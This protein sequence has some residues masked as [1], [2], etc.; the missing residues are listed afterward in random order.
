M[1]KSEFLLSELAKAIDAE[2]IGQDVAINA[3]STDTRTINDG[4]L[5]IAL[6]GERFDAHDFIDQAV[7]QGASAVVVDHPVECAIPQLVVNDTRIALGQ[8]SAY[9]RSLF[10]GTT[11]AITGSSGKTTVKEMLSVVMQGIDTTLATIGN[12]NNEIGVPLT[13]LRLAPE[14]RFAVIEMGASG[15]NEIAYSV[16]LTQPDIAMVNNAMA[17]HLEGFGSLEG[18]VQAKGEIYE[19][20]RDGG[21]AVVNLDDPASEAWLKR[22]PQSVKTLTY[23]VA[24][25]SA[26]ICVSHIERQKHGGHRFVIEA[27][28]QKVTAELS[29]LGRHNVANAAAVASMALAAGVSLEKVAEGIARFKAVKGRLCSLAGHSD[30]V[31]ID[32]TYNANKG[33]VMAAIDALT[34]LDGEATLVLGDLGELGGDAKAIHRELGKYA[35]SKGVQRLFAVGPLCREA[36]DG[37]QKAGGESAAHFN[38]KSSLVNAMLPLMTARTRI[39]VKGSRSSGMETVVDGLTG[40]EK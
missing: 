8:I 13:L 11:F 2:L 40:G 1:M 27:N 5:F 21:T 14:H 19:G 23:S 28:G 25:K 24:G 7:S 30:S 22:I 29:V 9:N 39:V 34:D 35:A 26:D 15:P 4:S 12:L 37:F 3:V 31:V 38:D 16:G 32:D 10:S 6:K 18:V 36:V 17:A 33:S 20:I